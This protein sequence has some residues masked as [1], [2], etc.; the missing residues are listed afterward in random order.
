MNA[1]PD[2]T[3]QTSETIRPPQLIQSLVGGFNAVANNISLILMPVALDLL[4]WFGPHVRIKR[5]FEPGLA[6]MM[7]YMRTRGAPES[8]AMVDSLEAMTGIFL[9]RYNLLSTLNTF[10]VGLPSQMAALGPVES[11]AGTPLGV[12]L[13]SFAQFVLGWFLLVVTGIVL[14]S[15]YYAL[16]ARSCEH[17]APQQI[18]PTGAPA[19]RSEAA[20]SPNMKPATLIWQIVQVF[21]LLVIL[22]VIL[23]VLMTP[24]LVISAL[25]GLFSTVAAQ[26]ALMVMSFIVLWLLIP[27]VFSPHA[28]FLRGQSVFHAMLTST[29]VVRLS[30]PATGLF[31]LALIVLNQGLDLLWNSAPET[32]WMAA[33]GIF[34]HAFVSTALLAAM[35]FYYRGGLNYIQFLR[36]ETQQQRI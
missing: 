11:P 13:G 34:G 20:F 12:E 27:L 16:V 4:L 17:S 8:R 28:I 26:F 14:G 18:I 6:E 5:L 3:G 25:M 31:L 23:L 2:K 35:F 33:V 10:P 24:A 15:I 9:E 36:R 19:G 22:L 32:S 21:G 30:M 1:S 7:E 29:R